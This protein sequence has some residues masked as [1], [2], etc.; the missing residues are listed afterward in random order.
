MG[1]PI[2]TPCRSATLARLMPRGAGAD[3]PVSRPETTQPGPPDPEARGWMDGTARDAIVFSA[4]KNLQRSERGLCF[5]WGLAGLA[6][7]LVHE[8]RTR[9]LVF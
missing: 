8:R 3:H 7:S 4:L 5:L 2:P 1:V 9:L 6:K